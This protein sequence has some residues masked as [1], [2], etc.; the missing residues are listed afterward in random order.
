MLVDSFISTS[1][2]KCNKLHLL[3][4]KKKKKKAENDSTAGMRL[5]WKWCK[6]HGSEKGATKKDVEKQ[7]FHQPSSTSELLWQQWVKW[8]AKEP[9]EGRCYGMQSRGPFWWWVTPILRSCFQRDHPIKERASCV[10]ADK[11]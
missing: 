3:R 7:V 1:L 10:P 8:N 11:N 4:Q 9:A 2:H 6:E 5:E